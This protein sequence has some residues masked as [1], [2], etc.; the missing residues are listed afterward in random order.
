MIGSWILIISIALVVAVAWPA[1]ATTRQRVA[2]VATMASVPWLAW[3]YWLYRRVRHERA[4]TVRRQRDAE[5]ARLSADL[6]FWEGRLSSPIPAERD[7]AESMLTYLGRPAA[8]VYTP[9]PM[10]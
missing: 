5:L 10:G 1:C 3:V 8:P 9:P 2:L 6:R 4:R 7:L